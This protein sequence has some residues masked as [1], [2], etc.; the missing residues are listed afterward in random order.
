MVLSNYIK[1]CVSNIDSI[2]TI[3]KLTIPV[4][5]LFVL[6]VVSSD[7]ALGA[8]GAQLVNR[9]LSRDRSGCAWADPSRLR[10]RDRRLYPLLLIGCVGAGWFTGICSHVY[11]NEPLMTIMSFKQLNQ[12]V[13]C[14]RRCV[15]SFLY[16]GDHLYLYWLVI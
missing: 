6:T 5:S 3:L 4:R 16:F 13:G 10:P 8:E 14:I 12:Y 2:H 1:K 9:E 15:C 7:A 11:S